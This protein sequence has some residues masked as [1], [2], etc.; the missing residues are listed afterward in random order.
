MAESRQG[1]D[2]G[3]RWTQYFIDITDVPDISR[4][5]QK[6][7]ACNEDLDNQLKQLERTTPSTLPIDADS[8]LICR[9]D[10]RW[11][12]TV[13]I[14]STGILGT[15]VNILLWDRWYMLYQEV[16]ENST[17][18]SDIH[19][20]ARVLRFLVRLL[21]LYS[22]NEDDRARSGSG[23][24][25]LPTQTAEA[26]IIT[27]FKKICQHRHDLLPI[28]ADDSTVWALKKGHATTDPQEMLESAVVQLV[29]VYAT[30]FAERSSTRSP[31]E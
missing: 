2:D 7:Q 11:K 14:F 8:G 22:Q 4:L 3:G 26:K 27:L 10:V 19:T 25:A 28:P 6:S 9:E 24:D 13:N 21:R 29:N 16:A 12:A 5:L 17:Q 23:V 1:L 18:I 30:A 20:P 31:P 15:V